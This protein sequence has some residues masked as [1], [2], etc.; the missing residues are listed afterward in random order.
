MQNGL[1]A[2]QMKRTKNHGNFFWTYPFARR[3]VKI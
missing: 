1:T 2:K 3:K